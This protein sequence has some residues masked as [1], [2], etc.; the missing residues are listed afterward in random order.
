[1]TSHMGGR[2]HL[3]LKSQGKDASPF[4][5]MQEETAGPMTLVGDAQ[6]AFTAGS[7][8]NRTIA[9]ASLSD[10]RITRRL[11]G[12]KGAAINSM[13]SSPDG[14]TIYYSASGSIWSIP[15]SGGQPHRLRDGRYFT[16]D[17]KGQ[18]L[19]IQVRDNAGTPNWCGRR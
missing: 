19:I 12:T 10:R 14:Q 8:K 6:V 13:V 17:P 7:G 5:D 15:T 18:Q 16:L 1:M 2:D 4:L 9:L 11:E 3:I